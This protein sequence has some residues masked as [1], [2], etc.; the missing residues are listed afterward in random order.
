MIK[1]P[2]MK[3]DK[4]LRKALSV[5]HRKSQYG[6]Q[7][8]RQV[9]KIFA[10][11]DDVN[12]LFESLSSTLKDIFSYEYVFI[13]N[14]TSE[15]SVEFTQNT[16][17]EKND[18]DYFIKLLNENLAPSGPVLKTENN[19]DHSLKI[20]SYA[21]IPIKFYDDITAV[22]LFADTKYRADLPIIVDTIL[23][24]GDMLAQEI[25][26]R[27]L[28]DKIDQVNRDKVIILDN[29][30]QSL[31]VCDVNGT[32]LPG[33]SLAAKK[34]FGE[35]IE[36]KAIFNA[37][38]YNSKAKES[39]SSWLKLVFKDVMDF[40]HVKP[41]GPSFYKKPDG[42]YIKLDYNIIRNEKGKIDRLL[43]KGLDE[44]E[45]RK[46]GKI[47]EEESSFAKS[48]L[49]VVKNVYEFRLLI[50]NIR[51]SVNILKKLIEED[52]GLDT[53]ESISKT[54]HTFKGN[55]G[56]FNLTSIS[57]LID[58]LEDDISDFFQTNSKEVRACQIFSDQILNDFHSGFE[59][60]IV[61][62]DE[63][64][65]LFN[66]GELDG[67]LISNEQLQNMN[68]LIKNECGEDSELHA[69]YTN[70]FLLEP[71]HDCFKQYSHL[72]ADQS[73]LLNKKIDY[74]IENTNI[75]VKKSRYN[76][77][78]SSIVHI[79]RNAIDHGFEK[80]QMRIDLGKKEVGSIIISF[81]EESVASKPYVK[82]SISDD[83]D[84]ID[85][86]KVKDEVFENKHHTISE[87]EAMS[88]YSINQ[89]IF[90]PY[91]STKGCV[92]S[93]SGRGVGLS[94]VKDEVLKIKGEISVESIKG[95]GARFIILIPI[96]KD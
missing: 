18:A 52:S 88:A 66:E 25:N 43:I 34:L 57:N 67:K 38:Q 84:G 42:T 69:E 73:K 90:L 24:I 86:E 20:K 8:I 15:G 37:F 87:L 80:P 77:L 22:L 89:L 72:V 49:A 75:L 2:E 63:I 14:I 26:R 12:I 74:I 10:D 78:L 47:A 54:L 30:E 31:I 27:Q 65:E 51:N 60:H 68:R 91:F 9:S 62:Y 81:S 35:N 5:L 13:S 79:L 83:G 36:G 23:L 48:A 96:L 64:L 21:I 32:V 92:S 7:S 46:L 95:K 41:L 4:N 50:E 93:I 70:Q 16:S 11:S 19:D 56:L 55:C 39:L 1:I 61:R 53:L 33:C 94:A 44:T 29:L 6:L 71:F 85:T 58:L 3:A 28:L 17:V 76:N 59:E 40:S 45:K 82:I